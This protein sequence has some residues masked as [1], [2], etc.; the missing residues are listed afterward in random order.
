MD[1]THSTPNSVVGRHRDVNRRSVLKLLGGGALAIGALSGTASAAES[2]F[3]GCD[4]L[5]TDTDGNFAVV[6]TGDGY[7]GRE[8]EPA[9]YQGNVTWTHENT[10]CYE[11]A[12]DESIVGFVYE[13]QFSGEI[14]TGRGCMLCLN[15]NECAADHHDGPED[16]AQNIDEST[17]G[18]CADS[19]AHGECEIA[20]ADREAAEAGHDVPLL[21]FALTLEHLEHAFYR[22]GLE[23]F[24]DE[25][26]V[27]ADVLADFGEEVRR[28]V[29]EY[30]R[31]IANHEA[32]HVVA[33]TG[34]VRDLGGKP[35][36][37]GEYAFGYETPS[38]FLETARALEDTGVAAYTGGAPTIVDNDVLGS[39]ASIQS[40]E[41]R[42]AAFLRLITDEVP[43]PSVVEEAA[44]IQEVLD[45]AGQYIA[46]EVDPSRYEIPDDQPEFD[47]KASD[48]TSDLDVLNYALT[49]EHLENAFYRDGLEEF[50][51]E[52]LMDADVLSA[53]DESVRETIPEYLETV[54]EHE[55]AH[56]ETVTETI[57]DLGGTPVEEATYD[58]GYESPSEFLGVAAAL[59]TTGVSAYRGAAPTVE[60]DDVFAAAVGIHAVEARH[61][62]YLNELTLDSPFPQAFDEAMTMEE[63]T[64]VASQ[65][66]VEE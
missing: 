66:I 62:A 50:D 7:E 41:A 51:D 48:E 14:E 34:T 47:R 64:G 38:E 3:F 1:D 24:D 54:G 23:V 16:I 61:S 15:P 59:E 52:E 9:P 37:E 6:A 4:R 42:H 5:C 44:S 21:N 32:Q 29:P 31:T 36:G 53:Y 25:E 43:F 40:V 20:G 19:L 46:S 27:E 26:L 11:A 30:L 49:L 45:T 10:F 63:V 18:P 17:I 55:A 22:E 28:Q 12:S 35:V 13:R 56:V 39:A 60:N 8:L 33:I 58:F 65:F 2:V 57:E